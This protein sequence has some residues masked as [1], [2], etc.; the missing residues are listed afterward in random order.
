MEFYLV[1][2]I[3]SKKIHRLG[4]EFS[5]TSVYGREKKMQLSCN[6]FKF[7]S[8]YFISLSFMFIVSIL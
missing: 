1:L 8:I 3:A 6:F 7:S 5:V 2:P 4:G